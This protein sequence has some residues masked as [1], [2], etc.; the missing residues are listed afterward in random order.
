MTVQPRIE[1]Y[2]DGTVVVNL[3]DAKTKQVVWQGE[4]ADVVNLPVANP[5][6]ATQQIDAAVEKLF[7]KYPPQ[8]SGARGELRPS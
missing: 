1:T 8:S 4:V 3:I 6:R 7:A 2:T 5:V